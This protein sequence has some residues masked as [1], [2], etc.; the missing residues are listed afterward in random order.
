[1]RGKGYPYRERKKEK[2]KLPQDKRP[3]V[4]CGTGIP[5]KTTVA[6][7]ERR[8]YVPRKKATKD[9][10][11]WT[12]S[13]CFTLIDMWAEISW[14]PAHKPKFHTDMAKLAMYFQKLW[15]KQHGKCAISNIDLAG[16]PSCRSKGIGIDI[17]NY[18]RGVE[19]GNIRLVS[20]PIAMT[21]LIDIDL[22]TQSMAPMLMD[23]YDEWS[24][25]AAIMKHIQ[26]A[27]K[28]RPFRWLPVMIQF[29]TPAQVENK[30][31][32]WIE[33]VSTIRYPSDNTIDGWMACSETDQFTFFS[34]QFHDGD[35]V[36]VDKAN[37][38]FN[39]KVMMQAG[40][41][42]KRLPLC[43][44]SIDLVHEVV[45]LAKSQFRT[46]MAKFLLSMDR[47]YY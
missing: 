10:Y 38:D 12:K 3:H 9:L 5:Y 32:S 17:I 37:W 36:C 14:I 46:S 39:Y 22:R 35:L 19:K 41:I 42:L 13:E 23:A 2:S 27:F 15:R 1:M 28:K 24:I 6:E 29:K 4:V 26:F 18:D 34:V 43:D 30:N 11:I 21:R 20:A 31:K 40:T 7:T 16:A 45:K 44:P 25:Y 47:T 33:F 8:F